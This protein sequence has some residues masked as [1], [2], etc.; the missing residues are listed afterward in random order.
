M[1]HVPAT[2]Y[3]SAKSNDECQ[4]QACECDKSA[5]ECFAYSQE[6]PG[7]LFYREC[8]CSYT[9]ENAAISRV[10]NVNMY[11]FKPINNSKNGYTSY[12][13]RFETLWE[14]LASYLGLNFLIG[15]MLAWIHMVL[16]LNGNVSLCFY[17][18]Y[19]NIK[20]VCV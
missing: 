8:Q 13:F 4:R 11:N 5:A 7:K 15:F 9:G 12:A 16:T 18:W 3:F 6:C 17:N 10:F 19:I 1:Y 20:K 2:N 14:P